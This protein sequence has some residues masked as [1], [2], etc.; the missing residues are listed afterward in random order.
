[1]GLVRIHLLYVR[2]Q[3]LEFSIVLFETGY[4]FFNYFNYCTVSGTYYMIYISSGTDAV[5]WLGNLDQ[6][7]QKSAVNAPAKPLQS[8]FKP[9]Y[10]TTNPSWVQNYGLQVQKRC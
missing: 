1:M 2:Q 9:S 3:T 10:A 6:F 4:V 5:Q 8:K 7:V